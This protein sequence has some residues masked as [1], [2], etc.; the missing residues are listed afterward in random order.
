MRT[1]KTITYI[2]I[3][4]IILCLYQLLFTWKTS[5]VEKK[6]KALSEQVIKE[7][8]ELKGSKLQAARRL[9][10]A[11]YLDSISSET[12]LNLGIVKYSY[13]DCK[14]KALN[15]GLDLQ[16]GMNVVL[17]VNLQDL[18]YNMSGNSKDK[19]FIDA[20]EKAKLM[21]ASSTEDYITLFEKAYNDISP[22]GKLSTI[23]STHQNADKIKFTSSNAE[24]IKWLREES[25]GA[26]NN[27]FNIISS[28]IDKFG[29]KSPTITLDENRGR[30]NVELAG[31]DNPQRVREIIIKTAKL[32]FWETYEVREMY[33]YLVDANNNLK[34]FLD[35]QK[36]KKS[37]PGKDSSST[38]SALIDFFNNKD[39][40]STSK[41][42]STPSLVND[43][44]SKE[45]DLVKS[46]EDN[47]LWAIFQLN[48][49]DKGNIPDK[50]PRIGYAKRTDTARIN[51]Y[52]SLPEVRVGMP[53]NVKFLWGKKAIDENGQIF[54]LYAI[55]KQINDDEPPLDGESVINARQ[56]VDQYGK[57]IVDMKMN[58]K[59]A[60]EWEQLTGANIE[61]AIAIVLDD[62]VYSAPNV[63]N[64]ISGGNSQISGNFDVK[65]ASDLANVLET[66]KLPAKAEIIEEDVIGPTLGK[67][68]ISAGLL[69]LVMA[70]ALILLYMVLYYNNA[71]LVADI[72]LFLNIFLIIGILAQ[73]GASL[74]LPGIAGIVLTLGMAVDA[75]VII[76]ERIREELR[77]GKT[78]K[79]AVS[80]GYKNS[81]SAIIDGNLTTII[82]AV[83]LLVFGIGPIKGFATTL[84]IGI[85]CSMITAVLVAREIME[86]RMES[87]KTF[88]FETAFSKNLLTN[89]NFD[90]LGKRKWSYIFSCCTIVFGLISFFTKG[91]ELGVDF[92]GG[93]EYKV[94]F[95][96]ALTSDEIKTSLDKVFNGGT[97]VKTYGSANQFKISTS[98]LI[99]KSGETVDAEVEKTLYDGLKSFVGEKSF[100]SFKNK[101]ILSSSKVSPTISTD[102]KRSSIIAALLALV[103]MFVYILIRFRRWQYS[104]G[105]IAATAH[106]TLFV[107][108]IFSIFSKILPF[109]MEID[110]AFIAAILTVIGYS[111]NDTVV[112][113]DRLREYLK[114]DPKTKI[115][116]VCNNA[117]N[118]TLTRTINTS[119]T[120]IFVVII[121]FLFGGASMKGFSFALI[122]GILIG[123]Y[124]SIFIATPVMVDLSKDKEPETIT[125]DTKKKK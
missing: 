93:R 7:T 34:N 110:Q 17:Q 11:K 1:N 31:V 3:I 74:T 10:N 45:N 16:G 67:R 88:K 85:I 90:F 28:R 49:D 119:L 82:T 64:K 35:Y 96:K 113:F 101:H 38:S 63:T 48:A 24:V 13:Q 39:T 32:E 117:I 2:V 108:A 116:E 19:N 97:I 122:L 55:K 42:D 20:L 40:D 47:P 75:N 92:K 72:V 61:R 107:L 89:V 118:S 84:I 29:V 27:T 95:D 94:Q 59:G 114:N 30:I 53:E 5:S 73:F 33:P 66:G 124:S 77:S 15:L 121:L 112:V 99:D 102:I 60:R 4:L 26:I 58:N 78:L 36:S 125:A 86:K 50:T 111:I 109:S 57:Y 44:S 68:A 23:F 43:S 91:F 71:G 115:A 123:T 37:N 83:I 70:F 105:A 9:A 8:P 69:S 56:N 80:E 41:N 100:E 81:L 65:E 106:D 12:V 87:G 18:I 46:K 25:S 103:A 22:K 51:Y 120:T 62:Q 6:A 79:T 52:L 54:D 14:D 98:Y 104:M 21:Q 76:N